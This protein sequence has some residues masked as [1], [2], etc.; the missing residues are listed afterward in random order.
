[1]PAIPPPPGA[2]A[3]AMPVAIVAAL[4]A[5]GSLYPFVFAPPDSWPA[6]WASLVAGPRWWTSLS[7]VAG[8]TL[9]FVPL[10]LV[11]SARLPARQ[12]GPL[13]LAVFALLA[14]AFALLLQIAQIAV[15]ARTAALSDVAWNA[16][17]L[18]L[19]IVLAPLLDPLRAHSRDRSLQPALT[20]LL[21]L[22]WLVGELAPLVPAFDWQGVKDA[23]RAL[24]NMEAIEWS[25]ALASAARTFA[26]GTVLTAIAGPRRSLLLLVGV[27]AAA[28][29]A[30][31]LVV[32]QS[33]TID[34]LAGYALGCMSWALSWRSPQER[35]CGAAAVLL[36]VGYSIDAL[37][38]FSMRASP[39]D[40]N[41]IPFATV[42]TSMTAG[43]L[44]NI[45]RSLF[46]FAT[47]G[48]LV[49]RAGGMLRPTTLVLS[50]WAGILEVAQR[51]LDGRTADITEAA[52]A[53]VAG[54]LVWG[55]TR[56]QSRSKT[57]M[58][59]MAGDAGASTAEPSPML[60]PRRPIPQ[61]ITL[62][63]FWGGTTLAIATL[64]RMPGIPYNVAELFLGNG[65][66]FFIAV[67]VLAIFSVGASA[68][69]LAER[70]P[71]SRRPIVALP[72]YAFA[73]A[74][75][76]LALL[77]ASV[78]DESIM[79]ISGSNN[80]WWFVTNKDIWGA[81]AHQLFAFTGSDVVA[82]FERPVR[83]A[84]LYI[85]LPVFIA[86]ALMLT[87]PR[88]ASRAL[89][90]RIAMVLVAAVPWLWLCK[91]IAFDWSSTDNLNELIAR[92][93]EYGW[94]GGGYLYLL[95]A[96][97]AANVALV[98]RVPARI[99]GAA[100]AAIGTGAAVAASWLLLNLGL[101]PHVEKYGQVFSGAQ[102]L[103]SPDRKHLLSEA[104]LLAR[105]SAVY[106]GVVILVSVGARIIW[107]LL[108]MLPSRL[109][110]RAPAALPGNGRAAAGG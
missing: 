36:I 1:M 63:V 109:R 91:G 71:A 57:V 25:V 93:G 85:P 20:H 102:F 78:T 38:P 55:F 32:G 10:G 11:Y 16:V 29:L 8:N 104:V 2:S 31:P 35:L 103:L 48:W 44:A 68:A 40:M 87:A 105:W 58:P 12:R 49:Q 4:I 70:L 96:L 83:F 9:L 18:L 99:S 19:G 66:P 33:L 24:R 107:P 28:A 23:L 77:Y 106:V 90:S 7:D 42:L 27:V 108:S 6:A 75:V 95:L 65:H 5:Y 34:D 56:W 51:W 67:F 45:F 61:L 94:G 26:L 62:A 59:S 100:V 37:R 76:C 54:V 21:V 46:V 41:W 22:L 97:F 110:S 50:L 60:E 43:N 3:Y 53:V 39:A 98:T 86:V 14:I 69:W 47:L 13:R 73:A 79:D 82:F 81:F 64:L 80:L 72:A 17:G 74:M 52:L 15:P 89:P 84:A 101:E 92:D 30:K 88:S